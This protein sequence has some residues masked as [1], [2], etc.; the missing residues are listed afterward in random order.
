MLSRETIAHLC[1]CD[2]EAMLAWQG[3]TETI[4]AAMRARAA[5]LF[6]CGILLGAAPSA[7]SQLRAALPESGEVGNLGTEAAA[8][9]IHTDGAPRVRGYPS[10][11]P[12]ALVVRWADVAEPAAASSGGG[13]DGG[14]GSAPPAEGAFVHLRLSSGVE[15]LKVMNHADTMALCFREVGVAV[16]AAPE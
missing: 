8:R 1:M 10:V 14:G 2:D 4:P 3:G 12:D 9:A 5:Q 6:R 7:H 16:A 15:H 11:W 13:G